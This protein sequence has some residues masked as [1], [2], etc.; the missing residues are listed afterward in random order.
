MKPL[1]IYFLT[2]GRKQVS[3]FMKHL[4]R[5]KIPPRVEEVRWLCLSRRHSYLY[6]YTVRYSTAVVKQ[7]LS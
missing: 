4:R 5:K 7:D 2:D 3:F 6:L 1:I